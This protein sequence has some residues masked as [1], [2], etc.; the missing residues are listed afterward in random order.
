MKKIHLA[1]LVAAFI[2]AGASVYSLAAINQVY[3]IKFQ[4]YSSYQKIFSEEIRDITHDKWQLEE[5]EP[6]V[7]IGITTSG[8]LDSG[9][10]DKVNMEALN[11]NFD[12]NFM[13]WATMGEETSPEYSV[14][15]SSIAQR[16]DVVE[17]VLSLSSPSKVWDKD[18]ELTK[19]YYPFDV[20]K[21]N[22]SSLSARGKLLF[23]FKSQTGE[24]LY[25]EY[26]Y[27]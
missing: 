7:K 19:T 18:K 15:F 24:Q 5:K 10:S 22:K 27:I 13:I 23:I 16:G 9:I 14:R 3:D 26:M 2:T 8:Y 6:K 4:W 1:L 20:I 25:S 17:V 11:V 12:S 21:I